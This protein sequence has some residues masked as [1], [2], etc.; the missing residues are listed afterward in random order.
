LTKEIAKAEPLRI[1]LLSATV[2]LSELAE[3]EAAEAHVWTAAGIG[4]S[5]RPAPRHRLVGVEA[6]LIVHLPL[7]AVA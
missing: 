2:V 3:I 4:I 1:L 6:V 5:F 7:L